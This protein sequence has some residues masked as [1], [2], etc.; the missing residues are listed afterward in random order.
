MQRQASEQ[1]KDINI[2]KKKE[3]ELKEEQ[4]LE[5]IKMQKIIAAL[6]EDIRSNKNAQE[7]DKDAAE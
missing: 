6:E 7:S 1:E 5:R 3:L 2:F 4:E